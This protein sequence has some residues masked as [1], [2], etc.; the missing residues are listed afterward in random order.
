MME[1]E[2]LKLKL[3]KVKFIEDERREE[4]TDGEMTEV[5]RRHIFNEGR[6]RRTRSVQH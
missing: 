1:D 3:F 6:G 5:K 4:Q 2:E